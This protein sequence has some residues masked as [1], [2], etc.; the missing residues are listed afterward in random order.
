MVRG[1]IGG[2]LRSVE[3]FPER[4]ALYVGERHYTCRELGAAAAELAATILDR[5][6]GHVPLIAVL[7][8]RSLTAYAGVLGAHCA[9]RGYVP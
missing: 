5:D 4:P 3:R 9:G 6:P 7:A 1:V 2:F 8:H